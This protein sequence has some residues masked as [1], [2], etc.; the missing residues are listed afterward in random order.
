MYRLRFIQ[1]AHNFC[2]FESETKKSLYFDG[3]WDEKEEKKTICVQIVSS[4]K[5]YLNWYHSEGLQWVGRFLRVIVLLNCVDV[6]AS[7]D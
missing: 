5:K 1:S 6:A 3:R 2:H 4:N 7:D